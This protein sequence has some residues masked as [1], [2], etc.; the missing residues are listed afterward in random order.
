VHD[1][2]LGSKSTLADNSIVYC[3]VT[4]DVPREEKNPIERVQILYSTRPAPLTGAS[5][6]TVPEVKN[7]AAYLMDG[8]GPGTWVGQADPAAGDAT[9]G[10][11]TNGVITIE[12][13]T[14]T[15]G[16][17]NLRRMVIV[18][19]MSRGVLMG[20]SNTYTSLIKGYEVQYIQSP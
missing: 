20:G 12:N 19:N 17:V 15:L 9:A 18:C 7:C 11:Y 3:P 8:T 1:W 16:S 2:G 13:A 5:P 10:P 6:A 14:A 4:L